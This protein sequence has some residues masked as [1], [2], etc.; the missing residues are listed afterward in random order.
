MSIITDI[1]VMKSNSRTLMD[2]LNYSFVILF[3][4]ARK[5]KQDVTFLYQAYNIIRAD[6]RSDLKKWENEF[7]E[8]DSDFFLKLTLIG[9]RDHCRDEVFS[10]QLRDMILKDAIATYN[11]IK[12]YPPLEL[13]SFHDNKLYPA[14]FKK[15]GQRIRR[16]TADK[17]DILP[18][19]LIDAIVN[20]MEVFHSCVVHFYKEVLKEKL[21][22]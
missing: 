2:Y 16:Y 3:S 6:E 7:R 17:M 18:P 14:I 9:I 1:N 19:D 11:I 10:A 12:E 4:L 15:L 13:F 5:Y 21:P 22:A 8:H 20:S